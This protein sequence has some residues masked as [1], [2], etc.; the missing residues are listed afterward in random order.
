MN[1]KWGESH[2]LVPSPIVLSGNKVRVYCSFVDSEFRGRVGFVDIEIMNEKP[3]VVEVSNVPALDLGECGSFSQYGVGLGTFWPN[4][5]GGD[6]YFV[7]F[8]RP[9]GFKFKAFSGKATYDAESMTYRHSSQGAFFGPECGGS[10]IVGVH[11]IF[12]YEG[13]MHALV[14]IGSGFQI[15]DGRE[16]PKYQVHLASGKDVESLTVAPEP[17]I[18]AELPV[19]RIGRPR[20]YSTNKGFEILVTA[21]DLAGNYL[22]RVFY[23]RDLK[24]WKEGSC[25]SFTNSTVLNFDDQHQCYLSRFSLSGNEYIVYNGNRMGVNGFGIAKGTPLDA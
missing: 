25:E 11:D 15:I 19:Y 13:L 10:T 22:P 7:G 2:A 8:D 17:I 6:L 20:I 5:L 14:S 9:T 3:Q 16:F 4:E 12:Q 23:S 18:S 24:D 1:P 21:G